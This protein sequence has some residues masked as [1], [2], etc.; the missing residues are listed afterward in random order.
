M[1]VLASIS[2]SITQWIAES[3]VYAVFALVERHGR[4]FHVGPEAL[5][6]AER[7]FDRFGLWAVLLGRAAPVVRSF[8]SIPAGVFAPRCPPMCC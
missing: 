1:I 5:L 8:I 4:R 2:S 6:R 3:G 7:W